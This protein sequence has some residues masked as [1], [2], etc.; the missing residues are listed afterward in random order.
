MIIYRVSQKNGQLA[1]L[2]ISGVF[3]SL[4]SKVGGVLESSDLE[5]SESVALFKFNEML[6]MCSFQ[7]CP[8]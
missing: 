4:K 7:I 6:L 5:L 8:V 2:N 3:P 1:F